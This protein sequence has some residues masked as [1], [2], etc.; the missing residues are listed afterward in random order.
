MGFIS[1]SGC[2]AF[3]LPPDSVNWDRARKERLRTLPAELEKHGLEYSVD[4]AWC[5]AYVDQN[6]Y[7]ALSLEK[8]VRQMR[9]LKWFFEKTEYRKARFGEAAENVADRNYLN[10]DDA[11]YYTHIHRPAGLRSVSEAQTYILKQLIDKRFN[12]DKKTPV[13]ATDPPFD[14]AP[15]SIIDRVNAEIER[16]LNPPAYLPMVFPFDPFGGFGGYD[17]YSDY[18]SD[19][20]EDICSVGFLRRLG[21][22]VRF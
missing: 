19:D 4:S 16:K 11:G 7:T 6:E 14:T 5:S 22:F 10:D 13:T 9:E 12:E 21:R 3:N 8:V 2:S 17:D 20:G 15:P 1:A 18:G